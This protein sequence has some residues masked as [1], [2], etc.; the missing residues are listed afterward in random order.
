MFTAGASSKKPAHRNR[1]DVQEDGP[2]TC[3]RFTVRWMIATLR[4]TRCGRVMSHV[5]DVLVLPVRPAQCSRIGCFLT[6]VTDF[7][8]GF[9]L[10][11]N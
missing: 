6:V 2:G 3:T 11:S 5:M 1:S 4:V 8:P 9:H 10:P 7:S